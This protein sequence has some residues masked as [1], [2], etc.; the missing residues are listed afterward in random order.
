MT[1]DYDFTTCARLAAELID[2]AT[3]D[4][5]ADVARLLELNIG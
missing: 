4:E 2:R 3:E 5:L 1:P